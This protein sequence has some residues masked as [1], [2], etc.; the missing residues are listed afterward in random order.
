[1]PIYMDRHYV[2]GATQH[3]IAGA[4]EKDLALQDKYGIHFLTYWFDEIRCTA[5][6]LVDAPSQEAV[7]KEHAEAHGSVPHEIIEVDPSV[8]EAFLGRVKDPVPA[9]GG[10]QVAVDSAFRAIMFTDLKDSTAMTNQLGDSRAMH[11]LHIHNAFTRNAL[12]DHSGSEVKHLGDGIM[13]SFNSIS[14]AIACAITLQNRFAAFNADSS[15]TPLHL[16]I[17][18]GAGEPVQED[19]DLFGATVQLAARICAQANPDQILVAQDVADHY[20][21]EKS[22]FSDAGTVTLKGFS[23]PIKLYQVKWEETDFK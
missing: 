17:G 6:C 11:L 1:M 13:A 22:I 12:R 21:G 14:N 5:F 10:G 3:A 4:H 8:V 9:A 2:V 20:S 7:Q 15:N 18:L 19:N 23:H 16:R